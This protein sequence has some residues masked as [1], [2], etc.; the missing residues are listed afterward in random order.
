MKQ[1]GSNFLLEAI[2][3]NCGT[4]ITFRVGKT[5]AQFYEKVYFDPDT[6]EGF[7]A[8]DLSSLGLGE[9]VCRVMTKGGFQSE[10][11][12]AQTFLP[13]KPSTE[14]NPEVVRRRSRQAICIPRDIIRDSIEERM[15]MDTVPDG[16]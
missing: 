12:S 8:N 9:V 16:S 15:K 6:K 2:F 11:F 10:P 1:S 4:T 3:N 14:A 7:K 13:V 5:D